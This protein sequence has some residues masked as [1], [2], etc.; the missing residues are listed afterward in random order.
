MDHRAGTG[1]L[2]LLDMTGQIYSTDKERC[3][4][5]LKYSELTENE[6][7]LAIE[8]ALMIEKKDQS[9]T[10]VHPEVGQVANLQTLNSG[11]VK[12]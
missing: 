12:A 11:F 5:F 10:T 8:R 4:L 6:L 9:L 2:F 1:E 3:Q 7:C